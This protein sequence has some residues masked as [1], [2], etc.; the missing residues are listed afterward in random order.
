VK[1]SALLTCEHRLFCKSSS[2]PTKK[3]PSRLWEH[4]C[5]GFVTS[6]VGRCLYC[7]SLF[8]QPV[9]HL[10]LFVH[11]CFL[12][13]FFC[14][15]VCVC[16]VVV[17]LSRNHHHY[18]VGLESTPKPTWLALLRQ[19]FRTLLL[20]ILCLANQYFWPSLRRVTA[21]LLRRA[22]IYPVALHM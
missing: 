14:V 4:C 7:T 12:L 10:V 6:T 17:V 16:V 3:G 18:I 11:S 1:V 19:H 9:L 22:L 13:F 15:C 2:F 5:S 21:L 20:L 8:S